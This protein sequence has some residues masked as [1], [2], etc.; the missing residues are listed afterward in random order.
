MQAKGIVASLPLLWLS[1]ARDGDW[2]WTLRL[3]WKNSTPLELDR[4]QLVCGVDLPVSGHGKLFQAHYLFSLVCILPPKPCC[5][6][7]KTDGALKAGTGSVTPN[8]TRTP[9]STEVMVLA[10]ATVRSAVLN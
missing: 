9:T 2:N 1:T 6:W 5:N 10:M 7:F 8:S 3:R 4:H